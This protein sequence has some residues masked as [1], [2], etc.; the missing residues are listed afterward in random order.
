MARNTLSPGKPGGGAGSRVNREVGVKTGQSATRVNPGAVG[1]L[2]SAQGN[3][4]MERPPSN[5]RGDPWSLGMG[6]GPLSTPLGNTVAVN[7]VCGVGGSRNLY[8]QSGVQAQHGPVN[9]GEARALARG[10]DSRGRVDKV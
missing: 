4:S 3:K 10:F 6:G 9:P 7:T 2:G 1:Q 5:Y 8:G